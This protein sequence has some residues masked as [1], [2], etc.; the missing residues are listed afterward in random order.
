MSLKMRSLLFIPIMDPSGC[1]LGVMQMIN[2]VVDDETAFS[3]QDEITLQSF[4]ACLVNMLKFQ[5]QVDLQS[6]AVSLNH[7]VNVVQIY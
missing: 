6:R 1:L 2:K 3:S 5:L 7:L 4:C